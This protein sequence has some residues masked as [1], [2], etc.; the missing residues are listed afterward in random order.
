MKLSS[1]AWQVRAPGKDDVYEADERK[2]AADDEQIGKAHV[3]RMTR[4]AI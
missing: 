1:S 4:D 2:A 3:R